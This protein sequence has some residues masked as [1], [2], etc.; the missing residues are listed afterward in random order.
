MHLSLYKLICKFFY[1]NL[2]FKVYITTFAQSITK[3]EICKLIANPALRFFSKV[4]DLT[5]L[6]SFNLV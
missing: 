6:K 3:K 5:Q 2:R 1:S 4:I